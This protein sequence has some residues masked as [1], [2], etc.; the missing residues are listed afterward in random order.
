MTY[1]IITNLDKFREFKEWLP[2]LGKG[3]TY[4]F[5]VLAR[6]KYIRH[7]D[8]PNIGTLKSDKHQCARWVAGKDRMELKLLQTE[9]PKG[10]YAIKGFEVPQEALAAYMTI[11][12]RSHVKAA[13]LAL[14]RLAD[15][16]ADG[17]DNPNVYQESLTCLHKA[18]SRKVFIDIDFDQVD[19]VTTMA[20][21]T[22]MINKD[23]L[24]AIFTRG[25]FHLLVRMDKID[26]K[27]AKTW[28]RDILSLDG[29]DIVGDNMIPIPGTYQ[30][31]F[32][33]RLIVNV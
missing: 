9:T 20:D 16:V 8:L 31:G 3:E 25:G 28:Y 6:N 4:Y 21:V 15:I 32:T 27:Y 12:P 30:G 7:L 33:P 14:K 17:E 11:N 26:P 19:Y 10:S 24:S 18:I 2:D 29:A 22:Q 5:S 13:K 23:C 1:K